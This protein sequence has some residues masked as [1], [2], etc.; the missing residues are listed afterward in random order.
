[1][2]VPQNMS[3]MSVSRTWI[4]EMREGNPGTLVCLLV[5]HA[6][7]GASGDHCLIQVTQVGSAFDPIAPQIII[8]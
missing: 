4:L 5:E 3:V 7:T 2:D 6:L 1:V 8:D